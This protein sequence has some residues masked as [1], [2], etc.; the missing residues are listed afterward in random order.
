MSTSFDLQ[1]LVNLHQIQTQMGAT[2]LQVHVIVG[3]LPTTA[4]AN[5]SYLL[6]TQ[7][8]ADLPGGVEPDQILPDDFL[9]PALV[10]NVVFVVAFPA[11]LLLT[12]VLPTDGVNS[13]NA[14]IGVAPATPENF[15]GEIGVLPEP[16][17][18][19]VAS[20]AL[21]TVA[22]LRRRQGAESPRQ[23]SHPR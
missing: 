13:F 19:A 8:F 16:G 11:P 21:L 22:A 3:N 6:A 14:T 9:D 12:E 15:A 23:N 5:R 2:V 18:A 7:G 4:T 10:D 20:A 1:N 17:G